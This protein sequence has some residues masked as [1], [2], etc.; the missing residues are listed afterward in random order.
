MSNAFFASAAVTAIRQPGTCS[1]GSESILSE[2][3]CRVVL[4]VSYGSAY[5]IFNNMGK[6][7]DRHIPGKAALFFTGILPFF[8]LP[9]LVAQTPSSPTGSSSVGTLVDSQVARA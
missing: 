9:G 8:F 6:R 7:L 2:L 1:T 5:Y 3:F 4:T